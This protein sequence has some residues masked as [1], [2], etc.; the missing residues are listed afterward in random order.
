MTGSG[1]S[2]FAYRY[3]LNAPAACRF[4]FDDLGRAAARL[5]IRPAATARDLE[6]ALPSRWLV[7]NPHRMFPGNPRKGFNYFC[8][9]VYQASKRGAGK[10]L[11]LVDEIWQWQT[12]QS[13]PYEL[14]LLVT[15]GREENIELVSCTQYPHRINASLT[16]AA[17]EVVAFRLDEELALKR[18][19]G[20]QMDA[21]EV[22]K[23]PLGQFIARNR[24]SG[25]V[26]RGKMF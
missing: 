18:I 6:A 2:T 24:L 10:K 16:G 26:I 23:L 21:G 15:T 5:K 1:K 7:F 12:A 22:Q 25:G 17:T 8:D 20:L 9:W 19:S 4:V 11:V 13:I 14:N 3:L